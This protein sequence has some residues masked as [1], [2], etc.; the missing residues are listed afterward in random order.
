MPFSLPSNCFYVPCILVFL[1]LSSFL[2]FLALHA[3][4]PF[5]L[6]LIC[7]LSLN[8]F[9]AL[10]TFLLYLSCFICL[11]YLSCLICLLPLPSILP[12]LS[13]LICLLPFLPSL[14]SVH[15]SLPYLKSFLSFFPY[16]PPLPSLYY[17]PVCH[18]CIWVSSVSLTMSM[19]F[20]FE[21]FCFKDTLTAED[22]IIGQLWTIGRNV[23]SV[24]F[25]RQRRMVRRWL[26]F[27][28]WEVSR[29]LSDLTQ[30]SWITCA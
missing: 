6:C 16:L 24:G 15:A 27:P 25:Q 22:L 8:I 21:C 20:C 1:V 11:L 26:C 13:C 29:Q 9:F 19:S 12:Y 28:L 14:P 30:R 7:I 17:I 2:T 23:F 18:W 10:C 4:F 3:F 5:L